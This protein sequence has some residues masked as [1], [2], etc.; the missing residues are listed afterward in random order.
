MRHGAGLIDRPATGR[1]LLT[2]ADRRSYLQGLLTNDIQALTPGTGCYAA[3]L[4]AQG[5]MMT[6]MRVLELGD[7]VLLSL[8]LHVTGAIRDHLDRFIFSEDVQV[9]DVTASRTEIGLYGP[10]AA[11]ILAKIGAEGGVPSRLFETTRVRVVGA[12]TVLVGSDELGVPGYDIL[13]DASDAEPV[14]AAL[15]ATG[16]VRVSEAEAET[17]RIESGRPR[18]GVDMDADTIPLEAGLEE[19][20]I[21]RSKGCYVGQE[22]IVRVQDRGQGRVAKRL[23]GLTFD[24]GASVPAA[25]ASILS[26][27]REIGRVTSA[28]WS[29]ALSRPIALGY[30][31]RDFA[32]PYTP[33]A[34][35]GS[36]GLVVALPIVAV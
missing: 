11:D 7:S 35:D 10:A 18:F 34:V 6:D 13:V 36:A 17:V 16:A 28:T 26:G 9:T 23:V 21:S 2:G 24:A 15:L 27:E 14:T 1:I 29:P 22:V 30:A 5:R 4:T 25:G 3:M 19:R 32:E 31:H 20:A 8:P 12:E 33:V